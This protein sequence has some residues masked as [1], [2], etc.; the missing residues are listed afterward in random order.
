M[1]L[2]PF[3]LGLTMCWLWPVGREQAFGEQALVIACAAGC[4]ALYLCPHRDSRPWLA[5]TRG[6]GDMW[7]RDGPNLQLQSSPAQIS[8]PLGA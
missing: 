6:K 2:R 8:Q 3:P 7:S 4:A 1:L 5:T